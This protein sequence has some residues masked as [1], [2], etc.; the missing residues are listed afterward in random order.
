MTLLD[1]RMTRAQAFK[2]GAAGAL[3]FYLG[4]CGTDTGGGAATGA[5]GTSATV[6]WLTWADHYL[7]PQL[8]AV[9]K[10]TGMRLRPALITDNAET[11]LKL[12]QGGAAA[13]IASA[14]ALWIPRFLKD[15]LIESFD[16]GAIKSSSELYSTARNLPF[17]Q[18]GG[19]MMAYPYG[20]STQ[21][22]YY[23]A[24]HVKSAPDSWH[25]LADPKYRK[26]IVLLNAPTDMMAMAGLATGSKQPFAM[27]DAEIARAKAFLAAV[28][29][30]VLKLG[31]QNSDINAALVDGSC[32]LAF[33]NLGT[34]VL[35]KEAGGPNIKVAFPKEGTIGF[36]DGEMIVATSKVKNRF[37]EIM[38]ATQS[39]NWI[40]QAFI[41]YGHPLFNEAAY[42][43]LVDQGHQERADRFFYNQPDKALETNL[44]GPSKNEQAY[45]DA[46]NEVFGA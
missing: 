38:Q 20:W 37:G 46:F 32:W 30:N 7:S 25:A 1:R 17:W 23:N 31:A 21:Q 11:L 27:S 16:L 6:N 40:A 10:Q 44:K 43:V 45:V 36:I 14:D 15:G 13:D 29:P 19:K 42:K 3:A 24:D 22:I 2:A 33:N 39:A 12:K 35:V 28:K 4:G 9:E 34:D 41:K 8:R 5:A 26:R 18:D